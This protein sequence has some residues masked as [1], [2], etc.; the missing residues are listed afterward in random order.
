MKFLA[1]SLMVAA[2]LVLYGCDSEPAEKN[3]ADATISTSTGENESTENVDDDVLHETGVVTHVEDNGY[4]T[5]TFTVQLHAGQPGLDL[6]AN[7]ANLDLGDASPESFAGKTVSLDYVSGEEPDLMHEA[8]ATTLDRAIADLRQRRNG[9]R[10]R[11]NL[12][13][14]L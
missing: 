10:Q 5:Y 11:Q 6:T 9:S 4:P 8:M 12:D 1:S 7:V 14:A 3:S 2:A 13:G